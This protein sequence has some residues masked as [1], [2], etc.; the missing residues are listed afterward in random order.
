MINVCIELELNVIIITENSSF[1][2]SISVISIIR[3]ETLYAIRD[4]L[5]NIFIDKHH[6]LEK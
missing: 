2:N 5:F 1:K 3:L 4:K 6:G